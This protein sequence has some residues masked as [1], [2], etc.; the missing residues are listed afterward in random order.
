MR[1]FPNR[2]SKPSPRWALWRWYDIDLDGE[3]YLTRLNI[4]QTPWFSIKLHWIHRPDADRHVHNHPWGFISFVLR[5]GYTELESRDPLVHDEQEREIRWFNFKDT[6][7]AHRIVKVKPK[8]L[9][10]ILSGP[11]DSRARWGFYHKD[12]R[13]YIDWEE[14][15][16]VKHTPEW[17]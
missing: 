6:N 8:T 1:I 9:T 10:L 14:Y 17:K 12:T 15:E 7:I 16:R 2:I 13:E 11:R 3:P 4:I 5:G